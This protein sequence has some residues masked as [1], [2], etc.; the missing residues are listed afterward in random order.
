M[1]VTAPP[2][3]GTLSSLNSG[4][5]INRAISPYVLRYSSNLEPTGDASLSDLV[6]IESLTSEY[7]QGFFMEAILSSRMQLQGV[8]TEILANL[9]DS[10]GEVDALRIWFR[11]TASFDSESPV[12]PTWLDDVLQG[13]FA[14]ENLNGY[15]I[16]VQ[17]L[18]P[19]NI[20]SST[21]D[22]AFERFVDVSDKTPDETVSS[23]STY[24]M[25]V[26]GFASFAFGSSVAVLVYF[27][28]RRESA[29]N[30]ILG[31]SDV[32]A[33][34]GEA[35]TTAVDDSVMSESLLG[36]YSETSS[37]VPVPSRR[38]DKEALRGHILY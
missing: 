3:S 14:E 8:S 10:E 16:M 7:L 37:A 38:H 9:R 15:L 32:E 17:A 28:R 34:I 4:Q 25:V 18:P 1:T 27:A 2:T 26:I 36:G 12:I 6:E 30:F 31:K 22:I 29:E 20:F 19:T 11:S 35:S 23:Y 33:P 13:A 24:R 21:T 5:L